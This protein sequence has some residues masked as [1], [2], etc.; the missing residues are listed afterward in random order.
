MAI[1]ILFIES[2]S[3]LKWVYT[4]ITLLFGSVIYLHIVN[5]ENSEGEPVLVDKDTYSILCDDVVCIIRTPDGENLE[6]D[7]KRDYDIIESGQFDLVKIS[8]LNM[9][10]DEIDTTYKIRPKE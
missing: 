10:G 9:L 3:D 6:F 2:T 4:F 1:T 7:T 5:A 8:H